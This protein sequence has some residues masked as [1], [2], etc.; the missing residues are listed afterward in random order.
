[1]N[2]LLVIYGS[3][4]IS[5]TAIAEEQKSTVQVQEETTTDRS[6]EDH[7]SVYNTD[8]LSDQ[9]LAYN[10]S[11]VYN[12]TKSFEVNSIESGP[13]INL[14]LDT[15]NTETTFF[16]FDSDIAAETE[17]YLGFDTSEYLPED[18]DP[19]NAPV[20][21]HSIDFIE[22]DEIE[23]GFD[24]SDYLPEGFNPYEVYFNIHNV[25]FVEEAFELGFDHKKYIM[26]NF[27][28]YQGVVDIHTIDFI[29][30]DEIELG[31]DTR[32]Y[33]PEGFDPYARSN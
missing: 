20:D 9:T 5:G 26:E 31:F 18:F 1:M 25:E 15:D 6:F 14:E 24:S 13:N 16:D 2:K 4:L 7:F 19:Y 3:V 27:D 30:D 22:E 17:L 23:L 12:Y 11:K 8:V 21:I 10:D 29:E 33:L 32:P 28:P